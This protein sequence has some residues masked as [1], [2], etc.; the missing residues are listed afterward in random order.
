MMT[1]TGAMLMRLRHDSVLVGFSDSLRRSVKHDVDTS[2]KK[3]ASDEESSALGR[4]VKSAVQATVQTTLN[5]VFDKERG[6]PVADLKD[7]RYED[8]KIV[9]Q[10]RTKEAT[11]TIRPD[12]IS[13]D[14]KPFLSQ[15]HPAD[16]AR[17]VGAV[18]ARM[19]A[20]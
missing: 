15:F 3:D 16:A 14:G 6:F 11:P 2:F 7:A 8:G 12:K 9:F 10:Y 20:R 17:F 4:V 18:R 19:G 1:S 13:N 5:E